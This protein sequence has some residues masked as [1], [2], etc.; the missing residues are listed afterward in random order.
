MRG[1]LVKVSGRV[2][3]LAVKGTDRTSYWQGTTNS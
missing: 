1:S 3:K 2:S